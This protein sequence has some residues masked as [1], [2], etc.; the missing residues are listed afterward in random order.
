[1][2]ALSARSLLIVAVLQASVSATALVSSRTAALAA[3][4]IGALALGRYA[5][6]AFFASTI[7]SSARA[8]LRA[9]AASAWVLGLAALVA[10]VAAVALRA[11]PALPWAVAAAFAGPF[12]MS[13]LALGSGLCSLS[14]GRTA[15]GGAGRSG[16]RR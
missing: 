5:A 4:A 6:V 16:G 13:A 9:F 11:R 1:M 2:D 14:A 15:S 12:G 8:G 10:A 7:G 3:G